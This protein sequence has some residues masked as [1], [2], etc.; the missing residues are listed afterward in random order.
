[1]P[2][3][4]GFT[5]VEGKKF[6]EWSIFEF[7]VFLHIVNTLSDHQP[8]SSLSSFE[9]L[10]L[11]GSSLQNFFTNFIQ[12]FGDDNIPSSNK[13]EN[14][15]SELSA[16]TKTLTVSSESSETLTVSPVRLKTI[17]TMRDTLGQL[18]ADFTHFQIISSGDIQLLKDK[19][20]QQDHLI[21]LQKQS[22]DDLSADLSSQIKSLQEMIS[23]QSQ[24]IKTLQDGNKSLQ[25]KQIQ[26]AQTNQ[27]LRESQTNLSAEI[28]HK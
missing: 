10:S 1:M 9:D 11:F 20:V 27:A 2:Q 5:E 24:V 6:E 21:K 7:P 28:N 15:N 13:G 25:K 22:V 12:F 18:E 3:P 8:L 16:P 14:N 19:I 17:T 26:I 23:Q 4:G